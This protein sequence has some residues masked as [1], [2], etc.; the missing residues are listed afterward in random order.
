[1]NAGHSFET[2]TL[3]LRRN[4]SWH[5]GIIKV[6]PSAN[7]NGSNYE[8]AKPRILRGQTR[9]PF[10]A[11]TQKVRVPKSVSAVP[12]VSLDKTSPEGSQVTRPG[13]GRAQQSDEEAKQLRFQRKWA[14]KS[15]HEPRSGF[16]LAAENFV[17]E[18]RHLATQGPSRPTLAKG[19]RDHL[20]LSNARIMAV[21][22]AREPVATSPVIKA[23][24]VS[25]CWLLDTVYEEKPI[26]RFW[27]LKV[28]A[29]SPYFSYVSVIHLFESLGWWRAAE[30]RKL[31]FAQE[32]NE[33]H[34][35][36]IMESLGGNLAWIDR[37][38]AF[39]SVTVYYW[40]L[41]VLYIIKPELSYNFSH[42][43][44][45]HAVDTCSAFLQV[46]E[47]ALKNLPAPKVAVQYYKTGDLYLF[48]SFQTRPSP[49]DPVVLRRP[50]CDNLY[51]TFQNICDDEWEHV[52]TMK[53]CE[54]WCRGG[55]SPTEMLSSLYDIEDMLDPSE[56]VIIKKRKA[57]SDFAQEINDTNAKS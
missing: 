50:P 15:A 6:I 17:E 10:R 55:N 56:V 37:F 42:L 8:G 9:L 29:R 5:K 13:D 21:E 57:W 46:N 51:D 22:V 18:A 47:D 3:T 31:H 36:L 2:K 40:A 41:V 48:D 12:T 25:L 35:L 49:E 16:G 7:R 23:L 33:M 26:Q 14:K 4:L 52:K 53:S 44:E 43:L 38:F 11:K 45:Y 32:W 24:Y 34:H 30:L 19:V 27:F 54:Q 28:V 39:H 20:R 1:M